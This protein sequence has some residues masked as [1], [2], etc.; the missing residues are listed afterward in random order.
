LTLATLEAPY[1]EGDPV[2][3]LEVL[4]DGR[5]LGYHLGNQLEHLQADAVVAPF[6]EEE[7][8]AEVVDLLELLQ[9]A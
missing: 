5:G 8:P 6:A 3:P 2:H 1:E 9:Q 7:Q 4:D